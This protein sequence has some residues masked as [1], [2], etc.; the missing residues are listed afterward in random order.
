MFANSISDAMI[1]KKKRQY[2]QLKTVYTLKVIIGHL[3]GWSTS[4]VFY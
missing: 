1:L 3:Y 2:E 4:T